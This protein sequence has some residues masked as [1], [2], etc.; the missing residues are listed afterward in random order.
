M[1]GVHKTKEPDTKVFGDYCLIGPYGIRKTERAPVQQDGSRVAD[2]TKTERRRGFELRTK[3]VI[4]VLYGPP[5]ELFLADNLKP[6]GLSR[7]TW[8]PQCL[9]DLHTRIRHKAFE[10]GHREVTKKAL[11]LETIVILFF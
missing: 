6:D 11:I 9:N 8:V 2:T 3:S 7:R 10:F 1:S 5:E 4:A